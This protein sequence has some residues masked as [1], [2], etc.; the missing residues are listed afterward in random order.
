MFPGSP[1][2]VNDMPYI[3]DGPMSMDMLSRLPKLKAMLCLSS[4]VQHLP[5][6]LVYLSSS[7]QFGTLDLGKLALKVDQFQRVAHPEKQRPLELAIVIA[8][9]SRVSA[10]PQPPVAIKN[11][12][13]FSSEMQQSLTAFKLRMPHIIIASHGVPNSSIITDFFLDILYWCSRIENRHGSENNY[14]SVYGL[15]I[16]QFFACAKAVSKNSSRKT[17]GVVTD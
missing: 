8:L 12:W 11:R 9:I 5:G 14:L 2:D 10:V 15:T 1:P 17:L 4:A 7:S 3:L 6:C 16:D 13:N